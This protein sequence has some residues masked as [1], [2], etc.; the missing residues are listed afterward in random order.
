MG[1]LLHC[2]IKLAS[3]LRINL[4]KWRT[5]LVD[6]TFQGKKVFVVVVLNLFC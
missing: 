2:M 3:A 1:L 5:E 6:I 4:V